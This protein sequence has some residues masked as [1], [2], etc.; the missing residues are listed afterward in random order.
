VI[1]RDVSIS[2]Q[3]DGL[4]VKAKGLDTACQIAVGFTQG[5]DLMG[6][7]WTLCGVRRVNVDWE[8]AY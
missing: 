2:R 5:N 8:A 6:W 4:I 3:I 7:M 1:L